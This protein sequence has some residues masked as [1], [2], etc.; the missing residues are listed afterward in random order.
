[1]GGAPELHP[2]LDHADGSLRIMAADVRV[3]LRDFGYLTMAAAQTEVEHVRTISGVVEVLGAG[4]GRD[5]MD[6]YFGRNNDMGRGKL[7]VAGAQYSVSLGTLLRRPDE[8]WGDGPDLKLSL[9][10]MYAQISADD[11]ARDGEQKYKLG[12]EATYTPLSWLVLGGRVDRVVPYMSAP[13][14]PLYAR[15][16]DNSYSVLTA[17]AVLR[18]DWQ[19]REALTLQYSHFIYRENFHV[20]TLNSGGQVS[21]VSDEPDRHLLAIYGTLWW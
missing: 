4:G 19:A 11:P 7:L 5:L 8:F 16:N 6:R 14:V 17:R 15:Q 13:K 9:F 2:E 3:N 1:M 10:G 20:V 21:T 12:A 18:S